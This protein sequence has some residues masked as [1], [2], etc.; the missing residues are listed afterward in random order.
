[1]IKGRDESETILAGQGCGQGAGVLSITVIAD[2]RGAVAFCSRQLSGRGIM[3]HQDGGG[4]LKNARRQGHGLRMVA[5]RISHHP[6]P[7]LCFIQFG[8]GIEAAPEL[9]STHALKVFTLHIDLPLQFFVQGTGLHH[10]GLVSDA[11]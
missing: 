10:R 3:R 5:R 9:K 11:L 4:N 2:D 7:P 6:C 1:M 8:Q